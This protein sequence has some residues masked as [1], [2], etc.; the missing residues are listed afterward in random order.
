MGLLI[1]TENLSTNEPFLLL[2]F[3]GELTKE[4]YITYVNPILKAIEDHQCR[5]ILCDFR[6]SSFLVSIPE[7]V[8]IHRIQAEILSNKAIL[9]QSIVT[10]FVTKEDSN[11]FSDLYFFKTISLDHGQRQKHFKEMDEAKDW[12]SQE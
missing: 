11:F 4:S 9:E 10:A 7:I 3:D 6:T 8:D 2:T 1:K 5:K 12:L